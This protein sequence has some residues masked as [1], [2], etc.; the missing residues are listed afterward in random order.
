MEHLQSAYINKRMS[1]KL[2]DIWELFSDNEWE[3]L[4]MTTDMLLNEDVLR[5]TTLHN[6]LHTLLPLL[7]NRFTRLFNDHRLPSTHESIQQIVAE[8]VNILEP[9]F[10]RQQRGQKLRA[11]N[12]Y[13]VDIL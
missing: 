5:N 12:P 6:A 11:N 8:F 2:R 3:I 7:E 13:F 4:V 10:I 9:D 1:Q